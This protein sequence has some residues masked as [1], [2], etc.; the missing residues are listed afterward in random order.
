MLGDITMELTLTIIASYG[1]TREELERKIEHA[2]Q[3][4]EVP[5]ALRQETLRLAFE[6]AYH[7]VDSVINA[8]KYTRNSELI[9]EIQELHMEPAYELYERIFD[10]F[11]THTPIWK[12][13]ATHEPEAIVLSGAVPAKVKTIA[14]A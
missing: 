11:Y 3:D 14:Y 2:L 12:E 4:V 13:V 8:G 6:S 10:A 9:T 7:F 1:K 5:V